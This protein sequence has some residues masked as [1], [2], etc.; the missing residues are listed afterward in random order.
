M[1]FPAL[2][3]SVLDL[4]PR[5]L[6]EYS[7]P[8]TEYA[9]PTLWEHYTISFVGK[10]VHFYWFHRPFFDLFRQCWPFFRPFSSLF[11]FYGHTTP[12]SATITTWSCLTRAMPER[13]CQRHRRRGLRH[14][15]LLHRAWARSEESLRPLAQSVG[16]HFHLRGERP[17]FFAQLVAKSVSY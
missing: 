2:F 16:Q 13:I 15:Q 6:Q 8:W 7:N 17:A 9:E 12:G 3:P 4:P 10:K 1:S 11:P 5:N 14:W